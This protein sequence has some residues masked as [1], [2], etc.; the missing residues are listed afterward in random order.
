MLLLAKEQQ[1]QKRIAVQISARF[2]GRYSSSAGP[3]NWRLIARRK[4][5]SSG[6]EDIAKDQIGIASISTDTYPITPR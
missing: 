3:R 4:R 6:A 5:V 1:L 2:R